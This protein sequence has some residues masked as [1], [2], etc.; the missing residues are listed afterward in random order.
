MNKWEERSKKM[1]DTGEK[2]ESL[3]CLLTILITIPLALIIF[4]G[5]VAGII[6]GGIIAALYIA[7][8]KANK[9]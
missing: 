1:K 7:G 9:K 4:I 8:R 6:A 5:P 3:G 2:M